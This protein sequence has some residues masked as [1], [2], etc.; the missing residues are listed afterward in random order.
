[1]FVNMDWYIE[2]LAASSVSGHSLPY[3]LSQ[4]TNTNMNNELKK[5]QYDV[6]SVNFRTL[7]EH[8]L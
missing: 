2:E 7:L 3:N 5:K 8:P 4:L 1:M 6:V